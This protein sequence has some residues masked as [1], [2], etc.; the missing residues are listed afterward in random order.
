MAKYNGKR[1]T[2]NGWF[3][4]FVVLFIVVL[5]VGFGFTRYGMPNIFLAASVGVSAFVEAV[6]TFFG[7]VSWYG[8][9]GKTRS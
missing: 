1:N 5:L 4:L 3:I 8:F 9:G 6:K 7:T 2:G